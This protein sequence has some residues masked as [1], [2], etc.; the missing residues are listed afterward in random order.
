MPR[1]YTA[2][3]DCRSD[4]RLYA[5]RL[6]SSTDDN[7]TEMRDSVSSRRY[8][9][10]IRW[11]NDWLDQNDIEDVR[12]LSATDAA[13][14]GYS[15]SDEF[16][17]T[18][19][20]N[21]WNQIYTFYDWLQ[22]RDEIDENPLDRWDNDKKDEFGLTKTTEQS[23]QLKDGEDYAVDESEIRLMEQN[24]SRHKTRDKLIIRMM[25]QTGLR[26]AEL[27]NLR[28]QDIDRD[29][30]EVTVRS[31]VAKNDERR[32]VAYQPSLDGLMRKWLDKGD[33]DALNRDNTD[34][35]LLGE[36]GG[37][38]RPGRIN[39]IVRDAAIDAGINRK[40]DYVDANDGERWLITAHNIRHGYGS[41]LVNETDMDLW[42]V[43]KQMGHKSVDTTENTYVGH[44][45][46]AGLE[47]VKRYGPK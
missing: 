12:D 28:L 7:D 29:T 35:L 34:W 42:E 32:V 43:S 23:R 5:R 17:G 19:G 40:L 3:E 15:I 2:I 37:R 13:Q 26:R 39:D 16:H 27:S 22:R 44:D 9:Q 36:R 14:M 25:W 10:D 8:K 38:L 4:I 41:Y 18:T 47:D 20:L 11:F 33:R 45:P 31:E 21:R 6:D 46:R 1:R 24:V 30:R